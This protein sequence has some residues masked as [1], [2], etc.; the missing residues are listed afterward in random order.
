[1][2]TSRVIIFKVSLVFAFG[3]SQKVEMISTF[4]FAAAKCLISKIARNV[5][6]ANA[7]RRKNSLRANISLCEKRGLTNTLL[8][9]RLQIEKLKSM[10]R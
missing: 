4:F 6:S 8:E 1:M 7:Y 10:R 3:D 9:K 5:Q 2:L